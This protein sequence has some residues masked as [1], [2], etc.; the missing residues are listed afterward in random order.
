M[1]FLNVFKVLLVFMFSAAECTGTK[2]KVNRFPGKIKLPNPSCRVLW[3]SLIHWCSIRSIFK[4]GW[5]DCQVKLSRRSITCSGDFLAGYSMKISNNSCAALHP[6]TETV[7]YQQFLI[8]RTIDH[9][10]IPLIQNPV[11]FTHMTLHPLRGSSRDANPLRRSP[12]SL[13]NDQE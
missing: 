4:K 1:A 12:R 10:S 11:E 3:I 2:I 9:L 5:K 6:H 7:S 8:W 13:A